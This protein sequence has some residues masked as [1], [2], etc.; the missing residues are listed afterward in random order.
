M[1]EIGE[2][3][4]REEKSTGNRQREKRRESVRSLS[5]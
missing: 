1:E 5:E 3:V 2:E 4:E